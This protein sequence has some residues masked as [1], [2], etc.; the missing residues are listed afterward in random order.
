MAREHVKG[1]GRRGAITPSGLSVRHWVMCVGS[2]FSIRRRLLIKVVATVAVAFVALLRFDGG[3]AFFL[4]LLTASVTG[5]VDRRV[6]V[7]LGLVSLA[8]CP[9]LLIADREAWLQRSTL[10]NYYATNVGLYNASVAADTMAVWAYYFLSIGVV[11][12]VARGIVTRKRH[13]SGRNT[14]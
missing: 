1:W 7:A 4:T 11:A 8:S 12:Q 3:A 9:L 13:E 5:L 14:I 2:V 6:S 10:V